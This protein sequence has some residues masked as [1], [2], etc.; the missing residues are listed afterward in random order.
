MKGWLLMKKVGATAGVA[1]LVLLTLPAAEAQVVQPSRRL[2]APDSTVKIEESLTRTLTQ[3]RRSFVEQDVD[4]LTG[5]LG[6]KK[7][8]LSLK[9]RSEAGYYTRSQIHFIFEKIFRDL[10]TRSFEFS[11]EDLTLS[12]EGRAFLRAEWTYLAAGSE[13][14][15]TD[16]LHFTFEKEKSGWVISEMKGA[17]R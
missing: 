12:Q 7:A 1:W 13:T 16:R 17:L 14:A 10:R 15:V 8:F 6:E 9:P 3:V 2:I 4:G 11:S 5:C